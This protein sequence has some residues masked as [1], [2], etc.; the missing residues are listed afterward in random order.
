MPPQEAEKRLNESL[1]L[2]LFL[3]LAEECEDDRDVLRRRVRE[4][5]VRARK[6]S[7]VQDAPKRDSQQ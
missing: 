5:L 1:I 6:K 2:Q 7:R 3:T 4:E